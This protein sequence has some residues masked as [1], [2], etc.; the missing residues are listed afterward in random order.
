M[1]NHEYVQREFS[2]PTLSLIYTLLGPVPSL[3][4]MTIPVIF[5][6][7]IIIGSVPG[8]HSP[9][10]FLSLLLASLLQVLFQA[11][12]ASRPFLSLFLASLFQVLYQVCT[13]SRPFLSL[14]QVLFQ[15]SIAYRPFLSFLLALLFQVLFQVFT[16][17]RPFLSLLLASLLKVCLPGFHHSLQ[18]IPLIGLLI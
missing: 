2:K 12:T 7:L 17:S 13:T 18:I 14:F 6:G 10:T 4:R 15:A 3:N 1:F 11:S 5:I 9:Q 16:D 8:L